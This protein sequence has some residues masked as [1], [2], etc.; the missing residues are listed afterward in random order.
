MIRLV[1]AHASDADALTDI[2][3]R[4]FDN[5][6]AFGAPGPG[7]PPG[8]DSVEWQRRTIAGSDY[9]CVYEDDTLIGGVI[10]G[11]GSDGE[12]ELWRLFLEPDRQNQGVGSQVLGLVWAQYPLVT[13]WRLDT[14]NWND[15][16]RRFYASN[17]FEE[18]GSTADGSVI[19]ERRS[20]PPRPVL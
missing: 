7:G 9:Y 2:S 4:A 6:V 1:R 3:R 10:I 8:Y 14:P 15:R 11:G 5:D 18:V 13:R 19:F 16:T 17:G 20:R 12:H